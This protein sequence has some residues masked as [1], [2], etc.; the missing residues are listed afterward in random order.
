MHR[1]ASRVVYQARHLVHQARWDFYVLLRHFWNHGLLLGG[2][3]GAVGF[4][5][6]ARPHHF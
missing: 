2:I 5:A 6:A 4:P 1:V 3:P